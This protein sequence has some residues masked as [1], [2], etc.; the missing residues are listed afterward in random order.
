MACLSVNRTGLVKNI[1]KAPVTKE[2]QLM[3]DI[4]VS[5]RALVSLCSELGIQNDRCQ[6]KSTLPFRP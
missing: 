4:V 2:Q 1:E 6:C 3:S 5:S